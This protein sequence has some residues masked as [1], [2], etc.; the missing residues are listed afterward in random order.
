M[1]IFQIIMLFVLAIVILFV[2]AI[3]KKKWLMFISII[4][5]SLVLWQIIMLFVMAMH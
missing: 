3:A 5:F 2:G 1:S 4:P